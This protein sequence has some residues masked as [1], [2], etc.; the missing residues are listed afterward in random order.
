TGEDAAD[1]D[2][3]TLA[4]DDT[5]VLSVVGVE[6]SPLQSLASARS[7][8]IIVLLL[9]HSV[10]LGNCGASIVTTLT[11]RRSPMPAR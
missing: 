2:H 3:W 5:P 10:G 1:N 4:I 7:R 11:V 6:L 9:D 8:E